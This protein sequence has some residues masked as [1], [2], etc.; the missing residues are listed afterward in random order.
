MKF[1]KYIKIDDLSRQFALTNEQ[2][3]EYLFL[4]D[5]EIF[6]ENEDIDLSDKKIKELLKRLNATKKKNHNNKSGLKSIKIEGLF[7]KY[8]YNL[9]FRNDI[10]IWISENGV[11][12]TTILTIIVAILTGDVRTLYDI[13]FK[14]ILVNISNKNYIIDK[15]KPASSFKSK[16]NIEY[17]N[18]RMLFLLEDLERYLPR[19]FFLKIRSEVMHKG[20]IEPSMLDEIIYRLPYDEGFN[21]DRLEKIIHEI[22]DLRYSD[23]YDEIY[24]IKDGLKEEVVFYPTYRRVE[25]GIERVFSTNPKKYA[26]RELTTKYMGFGMSD[27]KNRIRNLLEKLRKDANAAY[28]EMNANIISE[29]LE[30]HIGNYIDDYGN[31]DMHKVDVVIKRIGEDRINNIDKLRPFLTSKKFNA[32]NSNIDFLIYY[33]QKLVN[34]YNSQEAIDKKLG[35]FAQVCSKYLSGKKIEYDETMLT[36][37]VFD[38]D[39]FKID[40]DD[41]S[42]GEKQIVSI[43]SKVYLDVTSPCIFI[44]DE[45]EISLSIEWQ[46]EFLRDIYDSEKIALLIA[47]THS[48][49]IFKNE[50]VDYVKELEMYKEK[51][52]VETR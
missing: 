6:S 15:Q 1:E 3:L 34:I 45:P 12:K 7:G 14:K 35:K 19:S 52:D 8:D 4:N 37:N 16:N 44:I 46:K 42:S 31:I 5:I 38:N 11:G 40:F 51:N 2:L 28:I 21:I 43:F 50:Y 24:K 48:P 17:L 41:L 25:V 20:H 23:L 36:M 22:R 13:N 18:R 47:T 39:C 26:N 33:L 49:F 29:L 27:V 10:A 30:D 9:D 32:N